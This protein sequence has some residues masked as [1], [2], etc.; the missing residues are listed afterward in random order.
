MGYLRRQVVLA[1]L[2]ANALRP[3][4]N[5]RGGVLSFLVGWTTVEFAPH[6]LALQVADTAAHVAGRRRSR[7]GLAVAALSAAGLVREIVLSRAT[8]LHLSTAATSSL[9]ELEGLDFTPAKAERGAWRSQVNPLP[10]PDRRVRVARDIAYGDAP[11]HRL[12]IY[13]ARTPASGP[14]QAA[15]PAPVL[16]QV[17]GGGW[18]LGNKEQ[19]AVPLMQHMAAAG[20]ICVAINYRLAPRDPFPAQIIDVKRALAWVKEHIADYGGDP[21]YVVITGGSAGGHLAALAALT[22]NDPDFQPGFEEA[23]T[24]VAAAAPI[25]GVYDFAGATGLASAIGMR[26]V[27]LAPRVLRTTYEREP[28]RFEAGSPLLRITPDAPDFFVV[29][30]AADS[31]VDVGQARLFVEELRRHSSA[32]VVYAELPGAQHAFDIFNTTRTGHMVRALANYLTWHRARHLKGPDAVPDEPLG[33][34]AQ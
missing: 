30:G 10:R 16:L 3:A 8:G 1:A 9:G 19:Q 34:M 11:R 33:T 21:D 22:P 4:R 2:T 26:D 7:L 32:H 17:H 24:S 27:F 25:Y 18:V 6:L 28:E 31:L 20:W 13:S 29:H 15:G 23:D 5:L 12:D 14:D